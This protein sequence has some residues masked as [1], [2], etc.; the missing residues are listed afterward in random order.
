MKRFRQIL[1]ILVTIIF[2]LNVFAVGAG[3]VKLDGSASENSLRLLWQV[4]GWPDGIVGFNVKRRLQG[5]DS[6][7][8]LNNQAIYPAIIR[9]RNW[10]D[11]GLND[12]QQ[13]EFLDTFDNYLGKKFKEVSREKFG[14]MLQKVGMRS[15]DRIRLKNDYNMAIF[16][17]FGYIDND[18]KPEQ[19]FEYGLFG[20]DNNTV[21]SADPLATYV[22][23]YFP[24][25][26]ERLKVVLKAEKSGN[27]VAL[28]WNCKLAIIKELGLLGFHV[29][30]RE[31]GEDKWSQLVKY[32]LQPKQKSQNS[33][34][35]DYT[36][37]S[38]DVKK[39]YTYAVAPTNKFQQEFTK[40]VVKYE[41]FVTPLLKAITLKSVKEND[42]FEVI[43]TW[44]IP[45]KY[46]EFIQGFEILRCGPKE[47]GFKQVRNVLSVSSTSFRDWSPRA[48]S[49][50]KYKLVTIDLQGRKYESA[51]RSIYFKG[52]VGPDAVTGL[53]AKFIRRDGK[54]FVQ[55]NWKKQSTKKVEGYIFYDD[56][57]E[58]GKL[59]M[60]ASIPLITTNHYE[61]KL[62]SIT[63]GRDF[64]FAIE[65]LDHKR[66]GGNRS[67]L[68]VKVP[69]LK[70]P[71]PD[72]VKLEMLK[73]GNLKID[74]AYPVLEGVKGF[75]IFL[76]D[77][78]ICDDSK[79]SAK[80]RS[81][82]V[83]DYPEMD[84]GNLEFE[85]QAV[86]AIIESPKDS[87]NFYL[88]G[89]RPDRTLKAPKSFLAKLETKKGKKYVKLTWVADE[90][91]KKKLMGYTIIVRHAS[92]PQDKY[93]QVLN[94]Y[95]GDK[96]TKNLYEIPKYWKD[97]VL[98]FTICCVSK[99]KRKGLT[100]ETKIR[101]K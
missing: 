84:Q 5:D 87:S 54:N 78:M 28:S 42:R 57:T 47:T 21:E 85:L 23:S 52:R 7:G 74:W 82:I 36:D 18:F 37:M 101:I 96:E 45:K 75:R 25:D 24:V 99:T 98:T 8:K 40:S 94:G 53:K 76:Q 62:R 79:A 49:S 3:T 32:N 9:D 48:K 1:F 91:M 43:L 44:A 80:V 72:I 71:K 100:A 11:L 64:T 61:H 29:Y 51:A 13:K 56:E 4:D 31:K 77:K 41:G 55:L 88:N 95:F 86:N 38:A 63:G 69:L 20:V 22:S 67:E 81:Y 66:L 2:T 14:K 35:W 58:A 15:G 60:N 83:T 30:R 27:A 34:S 10:S 19:S 65:S 46:K 50:Y 39:F 90:A 68:T 16:L 17:G 33:N 97:G 12:A 70:L 26:D 93:Q 92:D 89:N 6:W 59:L 73:G